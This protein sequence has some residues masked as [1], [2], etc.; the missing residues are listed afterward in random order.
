MPRPYFRIFNPTLQGQKFD[1]NGGYVRTWVPELRSLPTK[2][3]HTPWLVARDR[4]GTVGGRNY[5][6]PVVEHS[7]A[8]QRALGAY[9]TLKSQIMLQA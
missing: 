6:E 1:P 3:I 5:P 2:L 8:R 4:S 7:F 9:G